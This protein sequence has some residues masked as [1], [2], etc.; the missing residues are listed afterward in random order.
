MGTGWTLE[1][2]GKKKG[3][4]GVQKKIYGIKKFPPM[5]GRLYRSALFGITSHARPHLAAGL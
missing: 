2:R 1:G 3:G 4:D 5:N